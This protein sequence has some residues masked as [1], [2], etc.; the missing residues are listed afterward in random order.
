MH[1]NLYNSP[2]KQRLRTK[3]FLETRSFFHLSTYC[4]LISKYNHLIPKQT[5]VISKNTFQRLFSSSFQ[6]KLETQIAHVLKQNLRF[7]N[8]LSHLVKY[9]AHCLSL[10]SKTF[11]NC[12]FPPSPSLFWNFSFKTKSVFRLLKNL[13]NR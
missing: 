4:Q 2:F 3:Y 8:T 7:S 1:V 13:N 12:R 11:Y 5:K 10:K 9:T 6:L